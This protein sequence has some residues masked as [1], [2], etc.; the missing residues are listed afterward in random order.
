MKTLPKPECVEQRAA[1]ARSGSEQKGPY[2]LLP[3]PRRI[4]L[5]DRESS[6]KAVVCVPALLGWSGEMRCSVQITAKYSNVKF[7]YP[8]SANGPDEAWDQS[9]TVEVPGYRVRETG[10]VYFV[11]KELR[12]A[13]EI[14][15]MSA[16]LA[17]LVRGALTVNG[18]ALGPQR[19]KL[20]SDGDF[21]PGIGSAI[22]REE[23]EA[24]NNSWFSVSL[25]ILDGL[26]TNFEADWAVEEQKVLSHLQEVGYRIN[27]PWN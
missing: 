3:P 17:F 16:A 12:L 20:A 22:D 5:N 6:F 19:V 27:A 8:Q 18:I 9:D 13:G 26:V 11:F 2:F 21:N 24:W 4:A 23:A 14:R 15:E 10:D 25:D 7:Q 1:G